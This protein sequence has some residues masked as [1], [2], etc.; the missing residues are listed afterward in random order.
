MI[1]SA[2]S[3]VI[4]ISFGLKTPLIAPAVFLLRFFK[5]EVFAFSFLIYCVLLGYEFSI[6]SAELG[7]E[8]LAVILSTILLL[9]ESV[10]ERRRDFA[11][12][13]LTAIA[14]FC[15]LDPAM[16]IAVLLFSILVFIWKDRPFFGIFVISFSIL[17]IFFI[18]IS[19]FGTAEAIFI[20][21]A[22]SAFLFIALS[23]TSRERIQH[24]P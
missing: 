9:E 6:Q 11:D 20:F 18:R 10:S 19:N 22:L 14:I 5:K 23:I 17:A 12:Y 1:S 3:I 13:I 16:I 7:I 2:S 24:F 8:A 21:A 4:A 15:I